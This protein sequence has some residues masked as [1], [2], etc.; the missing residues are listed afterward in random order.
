[1]QFVYAAL[2][3]GEPVLMLVFDE[4]RSVF[5]RRA[6]GMGFDLAPFLDQGL[7]HLRQIDPAELTPGELTAC[8]RDAV[9]G[10]G[11]RVVV[12]DSLSG[13]LN[14]MP[15]EHFMMLQMHEVL[16]YLNQQGIVTILVLAQHG[17]V[18]Q[19][20]SPVDLTYLSDSVIMLRFFESGGKL[21]RALSVLK[22][23]TGHHEETIREYRISAHG[24]SVGRAL[25]EFQGVLTG[26]PTYTGTA[27]SLLEETAG[28]E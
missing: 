1:M 27:S 19:M 5:L 24:V 8:V 25:T 3:R 14:A 15:E 20:A 2:K 22:K 9:E 16:S 7:L 10:K 26:V 6:Q 4:V 12:L 28:R 13:Y 23:R 11:V 18:G 17:M 21:R